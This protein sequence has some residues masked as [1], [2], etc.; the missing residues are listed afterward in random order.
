MVKTVL[1]FIPYTL[2]SSFAIFTVSM[3]IITIKQDKTN[4]IKH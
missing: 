3:F 4:M 2:L 1:N